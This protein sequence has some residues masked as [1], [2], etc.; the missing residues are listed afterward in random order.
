MLHFSSAPRFLSPPALFLPPSLSTLLTLYLLSNISLACLIS[1]R[2]LYGILPRIKCTTACIS[3]HNLMRT[4]TS[5]MN[6]VVVFVSF[7]LLIEEEDYLSFS[8]I[9]T[10]KIGVSFYLVFFFNFDFFFVKKYLYINTFNK[11]CGSKQ[12]IIRSNDRKK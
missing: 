8:F 10:G 11:M 7:F 9:L 6:V 5:K 12:T 1:N 2:I 4:I 3:Y